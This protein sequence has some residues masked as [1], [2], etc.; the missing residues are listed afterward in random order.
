M[1]EGV[2]CRECVLVRGCPSE[3]LEYAG[4]CVS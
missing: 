4:R 2:S 3:V 1:L